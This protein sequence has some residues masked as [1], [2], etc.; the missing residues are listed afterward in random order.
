MTSA[1]PVPEQQL[2]PAFIAEQSVMLYGEDYA[3][4]GVGLLSRLC[5]LWST[6]ALLAGETV[7]MLWYHCSAVAKP[8]LRYQHSTDYWS[9]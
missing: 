8:L 5:A 7:W 9:K 4:V 3:L 2:S 1:P 6:P